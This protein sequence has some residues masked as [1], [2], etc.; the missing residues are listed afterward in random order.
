MLPCFPSKV[1]LGCLVILLLLNNLF[2]LYSVGID[3][4]DKHKDNDTNHHKFKNLGE[5]HQLEKTVQQFFDKDSYCIFRSTVWN[6]FFYYFGPMIEDENKIKLPVKKST[7]FGSIDL[8]D[9][10]DAV[11]NLSHN[12]ESFSN[13]I[14][15]AA[16]G[17]ATQKQEQFNN[18]GQLY[19]SNLKKKN[20]TVFEFTPR[21]N[22]TAEQLV[23]YASKGLEREDMTYEKV[24]SAKLYGYLS[25]IHNDN[26]FRARPIQHANDIFTASSATRKNS[27]ND[28]NNSMDLVADRPYTF[29]LGQYLNENQIKT[30]IEFWDLIELM[31]SD[32]TTDDL[33]KALD[34]KPQDVYHFF[35]RNKDQFRHLR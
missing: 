23:E 27:N 13:H 16:T 11:Y 19:V 35:K 1:S 3:Q 9:L 22:F 2:L 34:R 32:K 10:V 18:L 33:E 12:P 21:H 4:L 17:A 14:S 20:Q 30:I 5:F 15:S 6:Q 24:D 29:P 26:R 7:K 28:D 31:N 25:H 8:A